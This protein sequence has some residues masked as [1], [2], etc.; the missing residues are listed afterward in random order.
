MVNNLISEK[1]DTNLK[2]IVIMATNEL[3]CQ[4]QLI[5]QLKS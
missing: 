3:K 5:A 4:E 2:N 1:I